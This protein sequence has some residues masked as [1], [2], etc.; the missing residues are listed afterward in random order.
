VQLHVNSTE[1][2]RDDS[3]RY[4]A[5]AAGGPVECHVWEGLL[6]VF[7]ASVGTLAAAKQVLDSSA[8]FLRQHLGEQA[9]V[10]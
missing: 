1:V 3:L 9:M 5:W 7:P 8:R 4:A 2:M 10:D 6:H